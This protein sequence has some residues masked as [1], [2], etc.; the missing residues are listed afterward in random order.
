MASNDEVKLAIYLD[1]LLTNYHIE[2]KDERQYSE[3]NED[4]LLMYMNA[5]RLE[6]Y[7]ATTITNYRYELKRFMNY[8]EKP[9]L[10]VTTADVRQYLAAFSHLKSGTIATKLT[11]IGAF[12]AWLVREELILK[13]P[14]IK[15]KQPKVPKRLREGLTIEEL[16]LV[17]ESCESLR[18]RALIEVFYSTAC[19]L[20]ELMA[21][22]ISDIN[23]QDM[24]AVVYGKGSKERKV[25]FSF[26]ALYHLKRYLKSR[27]DDCDALFV[28]TRRPFRR[29]TNRGIQYQ[30]NKIKLS[31]QVKK[32]L[33]PHVMRH[34][35]A[36]LSMDS[37]I[38]LTDLQHLLGHEDPATTLRYAPVSEE[39]KRQAFK[40]YHMQ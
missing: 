23:W 27:K 6:N 3:D 2:S 7:A 38:E 28:T 20:S 19:R 4:Y 14:T 31:S 10:K 5:I 24:S 13:S 39:R 26:K 12:Y 32:P 18:Q 8:V 35:F 22:N 16:E 17:R 37:G 1:D 29:L 30:I 21:M 9:M 15:I 40:K 36:T 33:T 11:I 34:T 25:F